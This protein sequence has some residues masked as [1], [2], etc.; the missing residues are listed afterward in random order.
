MKILLLDIE[1]AP[2]RVYA[3][4]LW[5]QNIGLNQIEEP[6]YTICWSAKWVGNKEI[7][8]GS[9]QEDGKKG[10]LK[11]VHTLL[12]E[13]DA[14]VHYNGSRFDIPTLNQEFIVVGLN[15]PAP[16]KQIDLL[17]T[18][19]KQFRLPSN[20]LDYVA[21]HLGLEGK[22]RHKGMDLWKGCM[23]GDKASWK[24]MKEYNIQDVRVLESVY[25]KLLPWVANH[26]NH[27]VYNPAIAPLCV[28]CGSRHVHRRGTTS[29]ATMIY[30]RYQCQDCGTWS[31]ERIN[32]VPK[33]KKKVILVQDKG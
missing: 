26:P 31:R 24:E 28:N 16:Y 8:Y 9:I 2:H 21:R 10:M 25:F 15:P 14:V 7:M 33:D 3:W 20:K 29:T 18:A 32:V 13:A 5:D 11:K 23:A 30:Q 12:S 22:M 19:K 4:G 27:N 17:K 1:T 6:G